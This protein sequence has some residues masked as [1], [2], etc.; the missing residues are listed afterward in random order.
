MNTVSSSISLE[1]SLV[2]TATTSEL[3][4]TTDPN[5]S[6]IQMHRHPPAR[7]FSAQGMPYSDVSVLFIGWTEE[8]PGV[9]WGHLRTTKKKGSPPL[10]SFRKFGK[11]GH[12]RHM[13][14]SFGDQESSKGKTCKKEDGSP[15]TEQ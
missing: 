11:K 12:G 8:L 3:G 2:T 14:V 15:L 7:C 13:S 5:A 10:R 4:R 9:L 6:P 1:V